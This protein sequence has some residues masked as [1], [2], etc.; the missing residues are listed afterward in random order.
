MTIYRRDD[1]GDPQRKIKR[2]EAAIRRLGGGRFVRI[3]LWTKG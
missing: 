3:A 1:R 2:L